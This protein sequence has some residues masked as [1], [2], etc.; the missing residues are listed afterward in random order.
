MEH[1]LKVR[2][3]LAPHSPEEEAAINRGIAEDPDNPEW[4]EADFARAKPG[5]AFP[6][7]VEILQK[8]APA[9]GREETA[10]HPAP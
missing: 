2:P 7:L 5:W 4:T 1:K 9:K 10:R 6:E 3:Y 8:P